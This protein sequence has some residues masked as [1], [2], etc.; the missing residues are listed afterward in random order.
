M[1]ATGCWTLQLSQFGS[2]MVM[3]LS[4]TPSSMQRLN[5]TSQH[6]RQTQQTLPWAPAISRRL[7]AT[8]LF[9]MGEALH[10]RMTQKTTSASAHIGK[11][12]PGEKP[13]SGTQAMSQEDRLPSTC[14]WERGD[15]GSITE[16]LEQFRDAAAIDQGPTAVLKRPATNILLNDVVRF[17]TPA[18]S[19][20]WMST[21]TT[22]SEQ[23]DPLAP[24]IALGVP[25][26]TWAAVTQ[27]YGP[28][29][30][31]LVKAT[32]SFP[33]VVEQLSRLPLFGFRVWSSPLALLRC[34]HLR[35]LPSII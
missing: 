35:C 14:T 8:C 7:L 18:S 9:R 13:S 34:F 4:V 12:K 26:Q 30:H 2:V 16:S 20:N 32:P 28:H 6:G 23:I 15:T 17:T 25:H 31:V 1:S 22:C 29:H 21:K 19:L 24:A 27:P 5:K 3:W 33:P 11:A 10:L